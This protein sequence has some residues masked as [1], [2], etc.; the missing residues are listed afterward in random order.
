MKKISALQISIICCII[1]YVLVCI[2]LLPSRTVVPVNKI[3][4]KD[5]AEYSQTASNIL[6]QGFFSL[7]GKTA[8]AGREPFY[9]AFLAMVYQIFGIENRVGIF[10]AQGTL[11]LAACLFFFRKLIHLR[12][13]DSVRVL[14]L[15]FLLSLPSIFHTIFAVYRENF[16]LSLFLFLAGVLL[17]FQHQQSWSKATLIGALLA[18]IILTCVSFVLLPIALLTLFFIHRWRYQFAFAIVGVTYLLVLSWG[19]RNYIHDGDF[20]LID[21]YRPTTMW[22]VRGEQAERVTGMEPFKCLWAEYISRTW[23]GR[24]PACN[25]NSLMHNKWPG[26][27]LH[28]N[29]ADIASE[30]RRKILRHFPNYLW[31]TV[32]QIIEYHLP[33]VNGWGFTYNVFAA[34]STVILYFGCLFSLSTIRRRTFAFLWIILGY[35]ALIYALTD[36]I[37][38]YMMPVIF[39]YATLSAV[40]YAAIYNRF[41]SRKAPTIHS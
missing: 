4:L 8:F 10:L 19:L 33:N 13:P 17:S 37:P 39:C 21:S 12:V 18:G 6:T 16:M 26:N 9:S 15:L 25:Y 41:I 3:F 31:F 28:G 11:Y 35:S 36:G 30:G 24:S 23:V 5:A 27:I 38:R 22:Y 1:F 29:E 20:R 7:D 2:W 34:I 32:T 40:G 14:C